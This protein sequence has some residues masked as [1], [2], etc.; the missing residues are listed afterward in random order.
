[1]HSCVILDL[2]LLHSERCYKA[3]PAEQTMSFEQLILRKRCLIQLFHVRTAERN[4]YDG[5]EVM[6]RR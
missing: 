6:P 1:M 4:K 2:P 5:Y 3:A